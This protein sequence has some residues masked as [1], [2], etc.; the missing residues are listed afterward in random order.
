MNGQPAWLPT[1]MTGVLVAVLWVGT[2]FLLGV[3]RT[4][5]EFLVQLDTLGGAT[6]LAHGGFLALQSAHATSQ[7]I[8]MGVVDKMTGVL[9]SSTGDTAR[10]AEAMSPTASAPVAPNV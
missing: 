8:Q 5:P 4:V 6:I 1:V 10:I 7:G 9:K 3:G 2:I